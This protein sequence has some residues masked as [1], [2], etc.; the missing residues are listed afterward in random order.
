MNNSLVD[1]PLPPEF[2]KGWPWTEP[3]IDKFEI[4]AGK[5]FPKIS[6][7]TPS[8]NQGNYIEETIRS[9]LLQNY[10]NLEYIVVDGGSTDNTLEILKKYENWIDIIISESDEG[11]SDAIN[12]GWRLATGDITTWINSDD[13][14]SENTL[15]SVAE[16][17]GNSGINNIIVGDVLNFYND[18]LDYFL[19]KQRNISLKNIIRFWDNK[20]NW[21]QPGMFFPMKKI[22]EV[23]Y[24]DINYHYSMDF[25]LLCKLLVDTEIIYSNKVFTFFRLHS[26]SKGVEFPQKTIKEKFLISSIYWKLIQEN[27]S[28]RDLLIVYWFI[29]LSLKF[30]FKGKFKLM[31][32]LYVDLNRFV[33]SL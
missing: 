21:H 5:Y 19:I 1:F 16:I 12:K 14:L 28:I 13:F 10:P 24:L 20:S 26:I 4:S 7:I 22:R 8:F 11:Q 27:Y 15:L 31:I 33:N 17:V 6:I 9:I 32:N 2:K 18:R 25:D 29:K 30:L 3:N 23:E